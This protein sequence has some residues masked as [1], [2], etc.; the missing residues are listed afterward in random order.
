MR[1]RGMSAG[2]GRVSGNG[3]WRQERR[4][5][6]RWARTRLVAAVSLLEMQNRKCPDD[7]RNINEPGRIRI[8]ARIHRQQRQEIARKLVMLS[9]DFAKRIGT[10]VPRG[11]DKLM[12]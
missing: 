4:T 3:H 5:N 12:N 6:L 10:L 1:F 2:V 8:A 7:A 11:N 9:D